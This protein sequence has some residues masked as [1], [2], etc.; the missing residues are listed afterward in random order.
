MAEER[1]RRK[2]S[3]ILSADVKGYSRLM[4]KDEE[5]TVKALKQHR[6]A[7]ARLV[8]EHRG[9]VV[10]SPGDNALAEFGSVVDATICAVEIQKTLKDKNATLPDDRKMSFRSRCRCTRGTGV[11]CQ[12]T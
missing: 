8:N 12:T 7:I 9:R 2:L 6:N 1:A 4:S 3:A 11:A 10:D 5:A